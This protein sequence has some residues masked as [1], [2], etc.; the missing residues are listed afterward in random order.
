MRHGRPYSED[1]DVFVIDAPAG[2][3]LRPQRV[4][5]A[6]RLSSRPPLI[7]ALLIAGILCLH[8]AGFA[9]LVHTT[10][11]ARGNPVSPE[12][13]VTTYILPKI[14]EATGNDIPDLSTLVVQLDTH[15]TDLHIDQPQF[16]FEVARTAG[17]SST[18]P[19][20]IGRTQIDMNAY[21]RQAALLPGEGA[22]VVL[23]IEV[24]ANGDAGRIEVDTSSGSQRSDQA[25]IDYAR[26]RHWNAGRVN[27]VARAV[28]IRWGVRLQA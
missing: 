6:A 25:A 11:V 24:L 18:A 2:R 21:V 13:T 1:P 28:W 5:L 27:G 23:R 4:A 26:T 3:P 19:S 7:S 16:E 12:S 22:T 10:P 20:L 17:A 8:W 15:F 9:L 14:R